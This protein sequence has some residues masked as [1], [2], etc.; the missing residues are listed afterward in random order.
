MNR[1]ILLFLLTMTTTLF[2][3]FKQGDMLPSITLENQ[4]EQ[5][6]KIEKSDKIL[7]LAFEKSVGESIKTFLEAQPKGFLEKHH[8][9]Y[10][11]DISS[12]P[13]FV[14]SWFAIP[15]MQEY[16]FPVMLIYDEFGSNFSQKEGMI[17][18]YHIKNMKI[19][20]VAFVT[21]EKLSTL[22]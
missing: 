21:P 19:Q 7:I 16:P 22:F 17:T 1:M 10:I 2:A 3:A 11:S 14:T 6:M 12:M 20:K 4:F 13:S 9:K 5:E 8:A 18:V 15:K